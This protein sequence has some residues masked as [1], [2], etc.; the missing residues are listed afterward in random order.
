MTEAYQEEF[1]SL[2]NKYNDGTE[3]LESW[4][5]SD[6]V[7]LERILDAELVRR[8]DITMAALREPVYNYE[9]DAFEQESNSDE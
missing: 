6:L 8:A 5:T 1:Y 2:L 4:E 9:E 7:A 3:P